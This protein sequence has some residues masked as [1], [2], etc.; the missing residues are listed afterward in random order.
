VNRATQEIFNF[1][2]QVDDLKNYILHKKLTDNE[3]SL[4][5]GNKDISALVLYYTFLNITGTDAFKM[6]IETINS[7][8][9]PHSDHNAERL[10]AMTSVL[11]TEEIFTNPFAFNIALESFCNYDI[12][13][14]TLEP[15]STDDLAWAC[16]NIMGIWGS[17][18]FPFT[19]NALRYMKA[20]LEWEHWEIPPI[21]F[22][23]P[24]ILDM[25]ESD[26]LKAYLNI[27]KYM[28]HMSLQHIAKLGNDREA[29]NMF[30]KT[31]YLLNYIMRNAE[32]AHNIITNIETTNNQIKAIFN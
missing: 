12:T 20:C 13:A 24:K 18:T 30:K 17:Y 8:V 5:L 15:Y 32:E 14:G 27:T 16:A 2:H 26:K 19:G 3:I 9:A 4:V 21:F 10:K 6:E 11:K 29:V 28:E 25:Y 22:S 23:F 1:A 31:P 7:I